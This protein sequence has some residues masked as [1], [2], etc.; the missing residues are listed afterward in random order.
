MEPV[1]TCASAGA[2]DPT[3]SMQLKVN[4]TSLGMKLS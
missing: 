1:V 3:T 2:T 4:V